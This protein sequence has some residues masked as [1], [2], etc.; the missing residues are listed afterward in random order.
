[1][2]HPCAIE[3]KRLSTERGL[4]KM[5]R[6]PIPSAEIT[7]VGYQEDSET[8]EIQFVKG[9]VYQFFNVPSTVFNEFMSSPSKEGY[10]HS[11]IGER[12]PCSRVA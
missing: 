3:R 12:F 6:F 7:Q 1:M 11:K 10:Y 2:A 5:N 8:L 4:S 9:G